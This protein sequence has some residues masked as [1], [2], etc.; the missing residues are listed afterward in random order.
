MKCRAPGFTA[1]RLHVTD[2][3]LGRGRRE[4]PLQNPAHVQALYWSIHMEHLSYMAHWLALA[5]CLMLTHQI[6]RQATEL[7]TGI[8][9]RPSLGRQAD[10][11]W[12]GRSHREGDI[13]AWLGCCFAA[14]DRIPI[15]PEPRCNPDNIMQG[16]V[17]GLLRGMNLQR[18]SSCH[19]CSRPSSHRGPAACNRR[20]STALGAAAAYAQCKLSMRDMRAQPVQQP[21]AQF[22]ACPVALIL[23]PSKQCRI[24]LSP[25]QQ[26]LSWCSDGQWPSP[27]LFWF[28]PC[29]GGAQLV[30]LAG[31]AFSALASM[32]FPACQPTSP[33]QCSCLQASAA[34]VAST[35]RRDAPC[36]SAS[37]TAEKEKW[38]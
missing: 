9:N 28:W 25:F 2:G 14:R 12:H 31:L 33:I 8:A 37:P 19:C 13:G 23:C 3:I 10:H 27:H 26:L 11:A 30:M 29:S 16:Y 6:H 17:Q 24:T 1:S 22:A 4:Q 32:C 15:G 20:L 18:V 36:V 5:G 35:A 21:S 7:A 34:H 38:G